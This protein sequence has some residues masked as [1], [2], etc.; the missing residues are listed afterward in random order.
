M[1]NIAKMKD[2]GAYVEQVPTPIKLKGK[3]EGEQVARELAKRFER[4]GLS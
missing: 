4:E 3:V 2:V 1:P